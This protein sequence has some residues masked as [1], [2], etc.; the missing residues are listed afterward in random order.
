LPAC[1]AS[2][3]VSWGPFAKS[4]ASAFF[5]TSN[6]SSR[7]CLDDEVRAFVNVL[8][9]NEEVVRTDEHRDAVRIGQVGASP[10]P[11]TGMPCRVTSR[12]PAKTCRDCRGAWLDGQRVISGHFRRTLGKGSEQVL[13]QVRLQVLLLPSRESEGP[14]HRLPGRT[15]VCRRTWRRNRFGC[16]ADGWQT[17]PGGGIDVSAAYFR[18][19]ETKRSLPVEVTVF[20]A[21]VFGSAHLDCP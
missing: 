14:S 7:E 12:P 21:G 10:I 15:I 8:R 13:E 5:E 4:F 6:G 9:A 20:G 19:A 3:E 17:N 11:S 18:H 16:F 1:G 2:A